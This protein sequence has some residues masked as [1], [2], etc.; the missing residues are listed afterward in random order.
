M[1]PLLKCTTLESVVFVPAVELTKQRTTRSRQTSFY[2]QRDNLRLY[3]WWTGSVVPKLP[4]ECA[5]L[6][7]FGARE[8]QSLFQ[9]N[10]SNVAAFCRMVAVEGS[11]VRNRPHIHGNIVRI[12]VRALWRTIVLFVVSTG[13]PR[14]N[15]R[16]LADLGLLFYRRVCPDLILVASKSRE[17]PTDVSDPN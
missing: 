16:S 9:G 12:L 11:H 6:H 4:E 3:S 8:I 15:S 14:P 1:R 5:T 7:T 13:V 10:V 2:I 17:P